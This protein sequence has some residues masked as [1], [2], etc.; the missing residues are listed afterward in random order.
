MRWAG[1]VDL[2]EEM[3]KLYRVL[4]RKYEEKRPFGRLRRRWENGIRMDVS[5]IGWRYRVDP[6]GLGYMPMEISRKYSDE[7]AG[8]GATDFVSHRVALPPTNSVPNSSS[9]YV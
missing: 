5:E 9:W 7:P 2:T 8:S 3:R 6:A 1:H 4:A